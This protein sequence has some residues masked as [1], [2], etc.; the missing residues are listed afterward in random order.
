MSTDRE[1]E[2]WGEQDPYFGVITDP[3]FRKGEIT[4]EVKH[5][6]FFSGRVHVDHVL[7]SC[8]K[9]IESS[10]APRRVL[11]F[12]C[13]VGRLLLPFAAVA[14]AVVGVDISEAMLREARRNCDE[15]EVMNVTLACS[16]D[17][18][19]AVQGAFDL[20]HSAIVL[21]HI[22]PDRGLR[23]VERLIGLLAP[24]GIGALQLTYGKAYHADTLGVV[25][26]AKAQVPSVAAPQP[27]RRPAP[28]FKW[29]RARPSEAAAMSSPSVAA[30]PDEQ[31]SIQV[32]RDPE[33]LMN[34]Y[35]LNAL[36][37]LLQRAGVTD[38]HTEFTD[39]GGE[40]GIFL[41]FR[42]P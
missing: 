1:W 20:V 41:F 2:K 27:E 21:Q 7:A 40:L 17:A 28:W 8:R 34:P 23:I 12:G 39:H 42:K 32:N 29:S 14:E 15:H 24:K 36:F 30:A 9:Y 10:F 33:M 26:P 31:Q 22:D 35:N 5:E 13:G 25:P 38:F 16:D 4:S 19:S 6:F 11:D 18:L 37:F 3:R